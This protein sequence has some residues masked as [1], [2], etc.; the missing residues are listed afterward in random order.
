MMKKASLFVDRLSEFFAQRK[1]LLPLVGM[2]LILVNLILQFFPLGWLNSSN[3][4]LHLGVLFAILGF[5]LA[6]AL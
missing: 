1:G 4:L 6:W 3:L 5:M 2:C